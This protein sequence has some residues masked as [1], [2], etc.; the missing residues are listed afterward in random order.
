MLDLT[1]AAGTRT[2]VLGPNGAGKSLLLRL[3]HGLL[4][5]RPPAAS[6]G[7]GADPARLRRAPGHG[8]PAAGA[9]AALGR[10]QRR[11]RACASAACRAPSGGERARAALAQVGLAPSRRRGRRACSR[12]ASSSAWRSP[13]PGRSSPRCCSSTSRP[14]TSTRPRP[15]RS[16]RL[17][18]GLHER[19]RQD[20]HDHPRS[21]PG[22]APRRRGRVPAPGPARRARPTPRASS[23]ARARRRPGP[24]SRASCSSEPHNRGRGSHAPSIRPARSPARGRSRR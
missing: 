21:G 3:C 5:A 10:R 15:G 16:R 6:A 18:D 23:R 11:L 17:I 9:A 1:L 22:A 2:V 13:A 4:A 14:P 19:R 8:L 24:S 7:P 12:A 20:R